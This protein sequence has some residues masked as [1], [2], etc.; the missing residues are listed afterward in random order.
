MGFESFTLYLYIYVC[1]CVSSWCSYCGLNASKYL[2]R[3]VDDVVF[4]N[5]YDRVHLTWGIVVAI[6][7]A[8]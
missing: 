2:R 1:V 8:I 6:A 3:D 7:I 5:T 4:D